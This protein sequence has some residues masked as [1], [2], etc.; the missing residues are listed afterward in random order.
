[1]I[2]S[3]WR[4]Y[5]ARTAQQQKLLH[6]WQERCAAS[7][8]QPDTLLP[9]QELQSG[10]VRLMLM[11]LMPFGSSRSTRTL[12]RGEPLGL[13][14]VSNSTHGAAAHHS[15]NSGIRDSRSRAVAVRGTIALVLR[16]ISSR[17]D[18]LNY[19]SLATAGDA[20]VNSC[21]QQAYQ[22]DKTHVQEFG[23]WKRPVAAPHKPAAR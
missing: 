15:S 18:E 13:G 11:A 4:S 7:A 9:A 19:T 23:L 14:V 8:A 1:M 20:Q 22:L 3:H 17:Q 6:Q 2:Q 10:A 12:E 5:A 16:S 21:A